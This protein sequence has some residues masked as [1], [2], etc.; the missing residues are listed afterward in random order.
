MACF[1]FSDICLTSHFC[2]CVIN[3]LSCLHHTLS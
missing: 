2:K 3:F 1:S